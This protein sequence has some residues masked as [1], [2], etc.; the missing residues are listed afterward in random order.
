[1]IH[2]VRCKQIWAEATTTFFFNMPA[3]YYKVLYENITTNQY[4]SFYLFFPLY[5]IVFI[6][7]STNMSN[8]CGV[9]GSF[10]NF[11]SCW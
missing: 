7:R 3:M 5:N 9:Q 10:T 2:P 6:H 1:M 11:F 8:M 4:L